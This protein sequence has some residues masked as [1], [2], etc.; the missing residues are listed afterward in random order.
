MGGAPATTPARLVAAGEAVAVLGPPPRFVGRGGEKL[1]AALDRFGVHVA[2][3]RVLDAGASTGGFTDCL[4]QR[5]AATV[6]AVDVGR[7]QL[8]ERLRSDPRVMA[9]ERTDLRRLDV[10]GVGGPFR[11]V[12]ADLSFVSLANVADALLAACAPGAEMVVLVKPQFEASP[13]EASKGRGVITD[14]AIWRRALDGVDAALA[15]RGAAIMAVM[16]SPLRGADGNVE[17]P[18]HVAAPGHPYLTAPE[19]ADLGVAVAAAT[20]RTGQP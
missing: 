7:N 6:V 17:F 19:A 13:A 4:L 16:V 10:A 8:H 20:A 5:G 18:V 9:C 2:G 3:L 11:L 1:D 14:P 12:V 15:R